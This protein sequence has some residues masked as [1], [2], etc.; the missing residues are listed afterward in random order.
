LWRFVELLHT[1]PSLDTLLSHKRLTQ[2]LLTCAAVVLTNL[3][4]LEKCFNTSP[5]VHT[6]Y[7]RYTYEILTNGGSLRFARSGDGKIRL[8]RLTDEMCVTQEGAINRLT[9]AI[10]GSVS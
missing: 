2:S 1:A 9:C 8:C 6:I 7:T 4:P 10:K 3:K 5:S